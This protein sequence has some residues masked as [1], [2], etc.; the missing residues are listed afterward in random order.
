MMTTETK[1]EKILANRR[2]TRKDQQ[3]L[4][5]MFSQGALTSSDKELI[6]RIYKALRQGLVKVV[7]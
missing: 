4:M 2:I 6:N 5:L 1:I 7:D 3:Q